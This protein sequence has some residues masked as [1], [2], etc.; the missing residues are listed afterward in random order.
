MIA[1]VYGM[2]LADKLGGAAVTV[3]RPGVMYGI[4][5]RVREFA[6]GIAVVKCGW[7]PSSYPGRFPSMSSSRCNDSS[8]NGTRSS[9]AAA[10]SF[11]TVAPGLY[12]VAIAQFI[13]GLSQPLLRQATAK[14]RL[15]GTSS[16]RSVNAPGHRHLAYMQTRVG[17]T[18]KGICSVLEG[19]ER[20]TRARPRLR[21][22][23]Q[24]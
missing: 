11:R 23:P 14:Q 10:G 13:S 19:R 24:K 2:L 6:A 8:S 4:P 5:G 21:V 9:H 18:V 3:T 22:I 1:P 16:P 12:L 7:P 20:R 17:F 15:L